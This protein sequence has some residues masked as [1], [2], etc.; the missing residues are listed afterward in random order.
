MLSL[1]VYA[2]GALTVAVATGG[3]A[4][5]PA[6]IGGAGACAVGIGQGWLLST[7]EDQEKAKTGSNI[8]TGHSIFEEIVK[9]AIKIT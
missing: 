5:L 9:T 6:M 3:G 2:G 7:A 4:A 8:L 1:G